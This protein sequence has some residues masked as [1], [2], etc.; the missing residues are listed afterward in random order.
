MIEAGCY[1]V[2]VHISRAL[3]PSPASSLFVFSC[4]SCYRNTRIRQ[5]ETLCINYYCEMRTHG[6][7]QRWTGGNSLC[8]D[9]QK[10]ILNEKMRQIYLFFRP[11][12]CSRD[13]QQPFWSQKYPPPKRSD[14]PA[15]S[16]IHPR[17]I[18]GDVL[19]TA[20]AQRTSTVLDDLAHWFSQAANSRP[21]GLISTM[22]LK[23]LTAPIS[24]A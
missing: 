17:Q 16:P 1:I 18:P 19:D 2:A 20:I 8:Q 22:I 21:F 11:E 24:T 5:V 23:L 10:Y 13:L 12:P 14:P 4:S 9:A 15:P 3:I 6:H 7:S